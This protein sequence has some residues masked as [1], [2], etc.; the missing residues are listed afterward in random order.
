MFNSNFTIATSLKFSYFSKITYWSKIN[1][2]QSPKKDIFSWSI[3][4]L[5]GSNSFAL[6]QDTF[7]LDHP[8]FSSI[9]WPNLESS[10]LHAVFLGSTAHFCFR[11]PVN[12]K[13][14]HQQLIF[15]TQKTPHKHTHLWH[16]HETSINATYT[17]LLDTDIRFGIHWDI[18]SAWIIY[19]GFLKHS[20]IWTYKLILEKWNKN[21]S[22]VTNRN[23]WC[24][25]NRAFHSAIGSNVRHLWDQGHHQQSSHTRSVPD[26]SIYSQLSQ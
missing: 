23:T 12:D 10:L 14:S 24:T 7:P 16:T 18:V 22:N 26:A 21:V 19:P 9:L 8:I 5:Y 25:I 6:L 2:S 1:F 15:Q 11:R 4:S 3:I 17:V 13:V 20:I